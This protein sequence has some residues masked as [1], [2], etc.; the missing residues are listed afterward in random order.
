MSYRFDLYGFI[1]DLGGPAA[2]H[3]RLE[4][5]GVKVKPRTINKWLERG[6]A[7]VVFLVNLMAHEALTNLPLDLNRYIKP[8]G[9][10]GELK[11][12]RAAASPGSGSPGSDPSPC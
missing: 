3:R 11:L 8:V 1:H 4:L 6:N 10:A 9:E 12:P 7:D 2:C 5:M